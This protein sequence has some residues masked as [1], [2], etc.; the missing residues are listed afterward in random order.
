MRH[1]AV[2]SAVA[3]VFLL[4][5]TGELLATKAKPPDRATMLR[6]CERRALACEQKCDTRLTEEGLTDKEYRACNDKCEDKVK[7]CRR[8]VDE[9]RPA[10]TAPGGDDGPAGGGGPVLS[11]D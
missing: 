8:R 2:A 3:T 11:P 10:R 4:L 9:L 7:K 5:S 1:A 6:A